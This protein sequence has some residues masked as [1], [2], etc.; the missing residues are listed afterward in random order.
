MRGLVSSKYSFTQREPV[1]L[2]GERMPEAIGEVISYLKKKDD[3]TS[4]FWSFLKL[5]GWVERV[6]WGTRSKEFLSPSVST[7]NRILRFGD[8]Y[9]PKKRNT[10]SAYDASEG[11][12]YLIFL[13][14][15]L[16]HPESPNFFAVD[17]FDNT[18][19]PA[20][21]REAVKKLADC[22][23]DEDKQVLLTTHNPWV[24]DGLDLTNDSI[25]LFAVD[26]SLQGRTRVR[27][28]PIELA[29][30]KGVK[31]GLTLS[32]LWARGALGGIPRNLLE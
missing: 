27:R 17:N 26:R 8:R 5:T 12:L 10:I 31:K 28:V 18:M 14:I 32:E 4:S 16:L 1:G 9:M 6:S 7:A 25:R 20:M 2:H 29:L 24:L 23:E 19:H 11:A 22:I 13:A 3:D 21:A 30:Q 15:L